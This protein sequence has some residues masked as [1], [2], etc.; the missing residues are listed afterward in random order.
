MSRASAIRSVSVR[1]YIEDGMGDPCAYIR[2]LCAHSRAG[3]LSLSDGLDERKAQMGRPQPEECRAGDNCQ[4]DDQPAHIPPQ[5]PGSSHFH[6]GYDHRHR[7]KK[8][9][10]QGIPS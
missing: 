5:H 1:R 9:S 7:S 6:H 10:K 2:R 4:H 3:A 8:E